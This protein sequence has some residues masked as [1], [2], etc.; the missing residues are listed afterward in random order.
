MKHK[1]WIVRV[2]LIIFIALWMLLI[3]DFS[4]YD[5]DSSQKLSDKITIKIVHI[6]KP[7]YESLPKVEKKKIFEA[8]SFVVRKTAHVVEYIILGA[9][10]CGFLATLDWIKNNSKKTKYVILITTLWCTVYAITDEVHQGFVKGR[11]P[12][13]FDVFVDFLGALI[14]AVL[15][16][17]IW[18]KNFKK[19][20]IKNEEV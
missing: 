4:D 9:L 1:V 15:F 11:S 6:I 12:Q 14:A 7:S 20:R 16:M 18:N 3:F 8:T 13:E 10:V 19:K 5:G 2:I 17:A